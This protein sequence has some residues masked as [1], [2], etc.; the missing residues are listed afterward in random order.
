MPDFGLEELLR[1][2]GARAFALEHFEKKPL[3]LQ[4]S[5]A[6]Y[7]ASLF[8]L[9]DMDRLHL[10]SRPQYTQVFAIDSRR[11][12]ATDEY[13][14]ARGEVDA[15]RL[16]ELFEEGATIVHR[17]VDAYCA[18]VATL[19]RSMEKYFNSPFSANAYWAPAGG[20]LFLFTTTPIMSSRCKSPARS[21]GASILRRR[22]RCEM[23]I[24]MML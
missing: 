4:R 19:C 12:I 9:E 2:V 23:S 18:S 16:F 5:S 8:R 3:F 6:S 22:C 11:K 20:G 17:N 1:P 24:A 21:N 15:L 10:L 13:A 14:D 7:H